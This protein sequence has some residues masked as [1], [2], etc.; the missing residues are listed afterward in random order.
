MT[1]DEN[2]TWFVIADCLGEVRDGR[3]C[4]W[5][6]ADDEDDGLIAVSEVEEDDDDDDLSWLRPEEE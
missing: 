4:W 5:G 3:V 1:T 6:T 2:E